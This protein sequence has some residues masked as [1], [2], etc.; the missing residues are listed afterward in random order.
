M[1]IHTHTHIH[2]KSLD[3]QVQAWTLPQASFVALHS[4]S[5]NLGLSFIFLQV[6]I[7]KEAAVLIISDVTKK[8]QASGHTSHIPSIQVL[9]NA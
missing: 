1:Y 6:E 4:H 3:I 5:T 8:W 2:L 9:E 7:L